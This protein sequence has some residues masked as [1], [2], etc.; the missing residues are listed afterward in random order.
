MEQRAR[1]PL[2]LFYGLKDRR[3]YSRRKRKEWLIR[4]INNYKQLKTKKTRE[5]YNMIVRHQ[6]VVILQTNFYQKKTEG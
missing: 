5:R 4:Q 2:L 3:N 1:D 6:I